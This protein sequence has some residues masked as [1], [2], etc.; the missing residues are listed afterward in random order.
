MKQKKTPMSRGPYGAAL[1]VVDT[2]EAR[3]N[4]PVFVKATAGSNRSARFD[5]A[6]DPMLGAGQRET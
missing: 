6:A 4:S 1:R 3:E 2:A 5:P